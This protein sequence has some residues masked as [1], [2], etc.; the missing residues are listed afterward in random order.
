MALISELIVTD[1]TRD[2]EGWSKYYISSVT[3]EDPVRDRT[4]QASKTSVFSRQHLTSEGQPGL[5]DVHEHKRRS[6]EVQL[7]PRRHL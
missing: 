6:T 1:H 4:P 5:R 2:F 7:S 3:T